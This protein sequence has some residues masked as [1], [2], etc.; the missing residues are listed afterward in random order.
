MHSKALDLHHLKLESGAKIH[1]N[2]IL[3]VL[4]FKK[5]L[6]SI[7]CLEDKWYRVAFVDGKVLVWGKHSSIDKAKVNWV[8][9]GRIY[10]VVTPFPQ[11]LVHM[12]STM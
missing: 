5:N 12:E 2:N 10:R 4:G 8:H 9:E 11:A 3:Y 6:I 7:S 1:L